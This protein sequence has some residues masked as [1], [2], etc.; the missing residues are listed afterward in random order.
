L[1]LPNAGFLYTL[2]LLAMTFVGFT[3]I[4]MILRQSLGAS[5]APF[6][7]LVAR[8]FMA[9]G[10]F[11]AYA[12]MLPP[13]LAMFDVQPRTLWRIASAASGLVIIALSYGYPLL[14][15]RV[16]H[17]R[18]STFVRW[19]TAVAALVGV[20]L[21]ANAAELIPLPAPALYAAALIVSLVQASVGFLVTL[22]VILSGMGR[23]LSRRLRR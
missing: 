8:F 1:E 14:R 6:D 11:I 13:L 18:A 12:A 4:V 10:F 19:Q 5:L 9:W 21:L 17:E 3:A 16:M 23:R 2:A 22:N 7:A 20:V 15:F